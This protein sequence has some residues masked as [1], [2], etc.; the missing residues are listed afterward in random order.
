MNTAWKDR[1]CRS[2]VVAL[3]LPLF[4]MLLLAFYVKQAIVSWHGYFLL[5]NLYGLDHPNQLQ[6]TTRLGLFA[7]DIAFG[8]ACLLFFVSIATAL[9]GRR[10]ALW[11]SIVFSLSLSSLLFVQLQCY[12][13]LGRFLSLSFMQA[14]TEFS[15]VDSSISAHYVSFTS[16]LKLLFVLALIVFA[17]VLSFKLIAKSPSARLSLPVATLVSL[18]GVGLMYFAGQARPTAYHRAIVIRALADFIG[19]GEL[20]GSAY[21]NLSKEEML[22]EYRRISNLPDAVLESDS[23]QGQYSKAA[24][25][26]DVIL[27]V[28]ETAPMRVFGEAGLDAFPTFKRLSQN[29]FVAKQHYTTYPISNRAIFSILSSWYPSNTTTNFNHQHPRMSPPSVARELKKLGYQTALFA[30]VAQRFQNDDRMYKSLG[31]DTI[32]FPEGLELDTPIEGLPPRSGL[33]ENRLTFDL[34]QEEISGF[35]QRDQRYFAMLTP[36]LGH[37]PWPDI[38][39][40]Q[41]VENWLARGRLIISEQ[42]RWLARLVE[43]LQAAGKLDSTIIVITSDHGLRTTREAPDLQVGRASADSF[44]VPLLIYVPGVLSEPTEISSVTSHIDIAPTLMSL[45][46]LTGSQQLLQGVA[47]WDGR[48]AERRTF[49]FGKCFL[50][51]DAVHQGESYAMRSDVQGAVYLSKSGLQFPDSSLLKPEDPRHSQISKE[52]AEFSAFQQVWVRKLGYSKGPD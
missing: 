36:T 32:V 11:L 40:S 25:G 18:L 6:M 52:I 47:L 23:R 16:L 46:G 45:L 22:M 48:L 30:P 50:S 33:K 19:A 12:Y 49:L 43:Q 26:Y 8:I 5:A 3:L 4:P 41:D 38:S 20:D 31:I 21:S 44:H 39:E 27:L 28:M 42:D 10:L 29:A 35:H 2:T 37:A 17:S 9:Q 14:A 15:A 13:T 1:I 24:A 34:L 51:V 7:A